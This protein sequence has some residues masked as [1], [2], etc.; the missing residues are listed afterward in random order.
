[1][2]KQKKVKKDLFHSPILNRIAK[3]IIKEHQNWFNDDQR[4]KYFDHKNMTMI[5]K[6]NQKINQLIYPNIKFDQ[7]LKP[8]GIKGPLELFELKFLVT[9]KC[10][11]E[12]RSPRTARVYKRSGSI[13]H[14]EKMLN[15]YDFKTVIRRKNEYPYNLKRNLEH[16]IAWTKGYTWNELEKLYITKKLP[17]I[18][19][20][21]YYWINDPK[22]RSVKSIPHYHLIY[23]KN[24]ETK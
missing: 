15:K 1:M 10:N 2:P 9:K 19:K 3:Q 24:E 12:L 13:T 7:L 5:L 22:I 4:S 8:I 14:I 11:I 21:T 20:A 23:D 6:D 17:Y 18:Q 16:Q